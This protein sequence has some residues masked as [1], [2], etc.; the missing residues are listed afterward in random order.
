MQARVDRDG[1]HGEDGRLIWAVCVCRMASDGE[2]SCVV[3]AEATSDEA[4]ESRK[5]D[6]ATGDSASKDVSRRE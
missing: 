3:Q 6:Q 2:E 1:V 4:E 5:L